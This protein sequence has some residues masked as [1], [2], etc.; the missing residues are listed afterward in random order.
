MFSNSQYILQI[1]LLWV[2]EILQFDPIA[3]NVLS[4]LRNLR[5]F[6]RKEQ[7]L[8]L[9]FQLITET[10]LSYKYNNFLTSD[11]SLGIRA[12]N[13]VFKKN[14][15]DSVPR[16]CAFTYCNES[17]NIFFAKNHIH[18]FVDL[19]TAKCKWKFKH[20]SLNQ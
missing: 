6:L 9:V 12:M 15:W 4:G 10:A 17:S 18:L 11:I 8:V 2:E 5:Y 13:L 19:H 16:N 3:L 1:N 20:C 14:N 7:W